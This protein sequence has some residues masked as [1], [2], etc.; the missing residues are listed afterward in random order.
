MEPTLV[1]VAAASG[2]LSKDASYLFRAVSPQIC[3][4]CHSRILAQIAHEEP[5]LYYLRPFPTNS[6]RL[7]KPLF[8]SRIPAQVLGAAIGVL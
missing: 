6:E 2:V 1:S 7:L 4:A 3:S 5:G 8:I